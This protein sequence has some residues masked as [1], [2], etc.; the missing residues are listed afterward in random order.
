M[1]ELQEDFFF[2]K[3]NLLIIAHMFQVQFHNIFLEVIIMHNSLHGR[4]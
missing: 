3:V 2:V 4:I 1:S